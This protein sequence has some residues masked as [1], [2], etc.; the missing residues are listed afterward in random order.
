MATYQLQ[1]VFNESQVPVLTFEEPKEFGDLVGS[2]MTRGKH[3]T[4]SG[5]S[6]C[7][8]TTLAK[9]ALE[10]ARVGPGSQHWMSGRDH[11][12]CQSIIDLFSK[13]FGCDKDEGVIL[14][15]LMACGILVL[16]D[17]HHL[18]E[19]VRDELGKKLKRWNELHIRVFIIGIAGSNKA[20]LEF[21]EAKF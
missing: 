16:D 4:L 11:V 12:E 14:E 5:P 6:G 3:I 8:K 2:I 7:G 17:F 18:D 15:W 9:K 1:D 13:E 21:Q 19:K 20:L 10:K